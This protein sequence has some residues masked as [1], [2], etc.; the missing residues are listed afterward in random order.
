MPLYEYQCFDCKKRF[1]ELKNFS[2]IESQVLCPDCGSISTDRLLSP[3]AVG[4]ESKSKNQV[5]SP[6]NKFT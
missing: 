2:L 3:F 1:D 4:G 6:L 5:C